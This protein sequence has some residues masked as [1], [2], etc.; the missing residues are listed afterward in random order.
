MATAAGSLGRPLVSLRLIQSRLV[1]GPACLSP[2]P[3]PRLRL[4]PAPYT[5]LVR[6]LHREGAENSPSSRLLLNPPAST[7]PPA[8]ILPESSQL[9]SR[10]RYWFE[11][12]KGYLRFYKDGLKSVWENRRRLQERLQQTP[13][14]ERP[15]LLRPQHVPSTFS[16]AD[17]VLLWRVRHDLLRLPLFGLMLVVIGEFTAL[18]VIYADGVVPY[19]CRI[20]RQIAASLRTA[21]WRRKTALDELEARYPHGVLSPQITASVARTH[22]LRSLHLAGTVWDWLGFMPPGL[23]QIKGRLRM[24]FLEGDDKTLIRDG[25]PSGLQLEE[26]RIACAQRGI[27]VLG[28]SETEMRAWLGDWLRLTAA[29]DATEKRRRMATLLL[30]RHGPLPLESLVGTLST[31]SY[32]SP[33]R[34]ENWPRQRDFA[35]PVWEL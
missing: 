3:P 12:G 1:P 20:P 9:D 4:R 26:L 33:R 6:R 22:I 7:R 23:W 30:T 2:A 13:D 11:V 16:R 10:W 5:P 17:W 25:G 34:P 27:D 15:S 31:D 28:K 35:V 32:F 29:E 14:H 24:A 19:T 18:V 8:L 21:E